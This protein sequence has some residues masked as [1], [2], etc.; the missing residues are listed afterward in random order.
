[1]YCPRQ[2]T[3]ILAARYEYITFVPVALPEA[4]AA[5]A[6][7]ANTFKPGLLMVSLVQSEMDSGFKKAAVRE[8]R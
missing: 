5:A 4:V 6:V 7:A 8:I 1:M 2:H 3:A